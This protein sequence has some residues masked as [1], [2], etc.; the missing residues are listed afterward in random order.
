MSNDYYTFGGDDY[1]ESMKESTSPENRNKKNIL[2]LLDQIVE[3]AK[4]DDEIHKREALAGHRGSQAVGEGWM[5][6]HLKVL[7][8]LVEKDHG[9]V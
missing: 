1:Y 4:A 3:K 9:N 7:R 5:L 6:F 2:N 8:E